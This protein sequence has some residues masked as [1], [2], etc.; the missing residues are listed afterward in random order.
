MFIQHCLIGFD[1]IQCQTLSGVRRESSFTHLATDVTARVTSQVR[2]G[3]ER[4]E[5]TATLTDTSSAKTALLKSSLILADFSSILYFLTH[6]P[7]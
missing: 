4:L 2:K 3:P 5:K 6:C 7:Y 1:A